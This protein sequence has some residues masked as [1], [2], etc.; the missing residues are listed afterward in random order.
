[1]TCNNTD[2]PTRLRYSLTLGGDTNHLLYTY[3]LC[4]IVAP[5]E[6]QSD[7]W[8]DL[9]SYAHIGAQRGCPGI[10][11]P[12]LSRW[13]PCGTR[14]AERTLPTQAAPRTPC[15]PRSFLAIFKIFSSSSSRS[16][17][18]SSSSAGR[19]RLGRGIVHATGELRRGGGNP[20]VSSRLR[21]QVRA[22][23]AR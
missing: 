7:C 10:L 9:D 3:A 21:P 16:S 17:S 2:A 15:L 1:M 6:E 4:Q 22:G 5:R 11:S 20:R 8:I 19:R 23:V 14:P 12:S 13:V 18:S